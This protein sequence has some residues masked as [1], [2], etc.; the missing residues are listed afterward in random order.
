MGNV[1]QLELQLQYS[2]QRK[3]I[4][5]VHGIFLFLLT[6]DLGGLPSNLLFCPP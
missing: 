6:L 3:Q 5:T 4:T 1:H 2:K